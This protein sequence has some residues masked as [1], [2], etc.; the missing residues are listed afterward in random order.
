MGIG[1]SIILIAVGAILRFAVTLS[2]KN[3]N[4]HIVG[5]VLMVV[6]IVGL[7]VS[8]IWAAMVTRRSSGQTTTVVE[9]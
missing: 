2:T 5:D 4:W 9:R 6:G 8:L 3:V 1:I 7:V